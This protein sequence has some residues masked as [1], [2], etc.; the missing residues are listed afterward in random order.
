MEKGN[1]NNTT[2]SSSK[3]K[4][5]SSNQKG[6]DKRKR[7]LLQKINGVI[8]VGPQDKSTVQYA[9]RTC[10]N[11]KFE[12]VY[13]MDQE[14]DQ[15][16]YMQH[17]EDFHTMKHKGMEVVV[18]SALGGDMSLIYSCMINDVI[19]VNIPPEFIATS[20]TITSFVDSVNR[21]RS[22]PNSPKRFALAGT[23]SVETLSL[24]FPFL[25]LLNVFLW[26]V[27]LSY[28]NRYY[29]DTYVVATILEQKV[30]QKYNVH[31]KT[32]HTEVV[33]DVPPHDP[34]N[35]DK[36]RFTFSDTSLFMIPE[37]SFGRVMQSI[38]REN[39]TGWTWFVL[40]CYMWTLSV[41]PFALVT[42]P[43]PYIETIMHSNGLIAWWI[44]H[45]V[46]SLFIWHHYFKCSYGW[47]TA[48]FL[49]LL[50]FPLFVFVL[51]SKIV[52]RG[53]K[54]YMKEM[55]QFK[56]PKYDPKGIFKSPEPQESENSDDDD[57][58][59]SS[60]PVK[61]RPPKNKKTPVTPSLVHGVKA[62]PNMFTGDLS[63]DEEYVLVR[64]KKN[65]NHDHHLQNVTS[66]LPISVALSDKKSSSSSSP[67]P[68]A[69]DEAEVFKNRLE[70]L[71]T[72]GEEE[73]EEQQ[74]QNE[75]GIKNN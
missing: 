13:I 69:P 71:V 7:D 38:Y 11:A 3:S 20:K 5:K 30:E 46:V 31:T 1:N 56:M 29:R 68:S 57:D 66:T 59:H 52:W 28:W 23:Q 43:W 21:Q 37:M 47:V 36:A 35:R 42:N 50:I 34:G 40:L 4:K 33:V 53:G 67:S 65:N 61:T 58:E 45:G 64:V 16:Y 19:S 75:A 32:F 22:I 62:D 72:G 70:A 54:H 63:E 55:P 14:N 12:T 2:T 26:F 60:V 25:L 9:L 10:L 39:F 8:I 24:W 48:P 15:E 27:S 18:H 6:E 44:I 41:N 49:P 73:E 51:V 74:Q 17:F